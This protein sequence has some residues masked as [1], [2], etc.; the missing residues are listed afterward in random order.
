MLS[1]LSSRT[2]CT[3]Y[4]FLSSLPFSLLLFQLCLHEKFQLVHLSLFGVWTPADIPIHP[5]ILSFDAVDMDNP[6]FFSVFF[7]VG[8]GSWRKQKISYPHKISI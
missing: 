7:L 5:E 3:F 2:L 4:L 1:L 8:V 6:V